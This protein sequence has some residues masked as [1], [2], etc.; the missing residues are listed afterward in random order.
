VPDSEKVRTCPED[1]RF[2]ANQVVEIPAASLATDNPTVGRLLPNSP[3]APVALAFDTDGSLW[4]AGQ[5]GDGIVLNLPADQLG[6]GGAAT[7]R[8]CISNNIVG[9]NPVNFS[10]F[11]SLEGLALFN[12]KIWVANNGG[13]QPGRE[14]VALRVENDALVLDGVFGDQAGGTGPVVCPGGLFATSQ[15]L[16]VNDQGFNQPTTDC[17]ASEADHGSEVGAVLRFTQTQLDDQ[18]TDPTEIVRFSDITSR[19]GFGGLFVEEN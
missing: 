9:C 15:H 10:L 14:L 8:Y 7:P 11:K 2:G 17:G 12:G 13:N 3:D 4:V 19:P 18:V 1:G 6:Q 5:F 16:W